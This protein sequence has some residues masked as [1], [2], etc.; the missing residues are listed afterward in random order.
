MRGDRLKPP[1]PGLAKTC[2]CSL[3]WPCGV[4]SGALLGCTVSLQPGMRADSN[5]RPTPPSLPSLYSTA[6]LRI[7]LLTSHRFH[8]DARSN[9]LRAPPCPLHTVLHTPRTDQTA[10]NRHFDSRFRQSPRRSFPIYIDCRSVF[11]SRRYRC[12]LC[13]TEYCAVSACVFWETPFA[14]HRLSLRTESSGF[15]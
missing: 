4:E 11:H 1:F 15:G 5:V 3:P 13:D 10:D 12:S 9:S 6:T 2:C 7:S 14:I 8:A